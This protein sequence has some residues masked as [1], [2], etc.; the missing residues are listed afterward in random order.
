MPDAP[1][2]NAPDPN[3]PDPNAP[4]PIGDGQQTPEQL[5][6]EV[7]KWKALSRKNEGEA[8]ANRDAAAKLAQL[9]ESQK[10]EAQK[11]EDRAKAAE[12]A[13]ASATL[14]STRLHVA[15]TKG[16]PPELAV[17][18][19]GATEAEMEADADSLLALVKGAGGNVDMGQGARGNGAPPDDMNARLRAAAGRTA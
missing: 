5:K 2:P 13:L 12:T 17:R 8:K 4:D 7:D 3:A 11:L 1:D 10:T 6:A 18:L 14:N 15:L 9:E 16:L 19:Q